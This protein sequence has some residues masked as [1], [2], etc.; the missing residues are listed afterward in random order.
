MKFH[1]RWH[2]HAV[3]R[4][5]LAWYWLDATRG[6]LSLTWGDHYNDSVWSIDLELSVPRWLLRLDEHRR[7]RKRA[8][9]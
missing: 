3:H 8:K 4:P 6:F 1:A 7:E 2:W 5:H 9:T